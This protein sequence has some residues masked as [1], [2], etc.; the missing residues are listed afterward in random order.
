MPS[1]DD[2]DHESVS[3]N[4]FIDWNTLNDI[5]HAH[6]VVAMESE[7]VGPQIYEVA[8]SS[9]NLPFLCILK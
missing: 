3:I 5:F 1:L 2:T 4:A 7:D 8:D 6:Y 9:Y